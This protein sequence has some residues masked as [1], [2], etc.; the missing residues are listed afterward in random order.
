MK[1]RIFLLFILML[2]SIFTMPYSAEEPFVVL[3][4]LKGKAEVQRAGQQRWALIGK[5]GKLYNNDIIRV[6]DKSVIRLKWQNGSIIYVNSKLQLLINLHK[7][8]IN[9][10]FANYA[11]VFF[12]A[13]YFIVKKTLPRGVFTRQETKVYTPTAILAIRGTSFSVS[14]N[15]KSGF[16]RIG[17][18]NGTVLVKNI[19]KTQSL[20]LSAGYQT[21]VAMNAD[22]L[23]P[24]PLL[25]KEINLLKTWVPPEVI[26]EEMNTQIAQA[27]ADYATITG[28]LEEKIVVVPFGNSSIYKGKWKIGEKIATML[29]E[30]ISLKNR[31]ECDIV[32][33]PKAEADPIQIGLKEKARFVITGEI[34]HFE[35]IRRAEI[36]AAADKYQELSIAKI[37]LRIHLI[38]AEA[39][40]EIYKNDFCQDVSGKN[41]E[42]NSWKYI[43]TLKFDL[44]DRAFTS[45]IL[46]KAL[47]STLDQ[48]S[49]HLS[50]HMGFDFSNEPVKRK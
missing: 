45:S 7:D 9:N 6:L 17:I 16:T 24:E 39:K 5:D 14:V 41:I 29:A 25:K 15:K 23:L 26:I 36:T 34:E 32:S 27:K 2:F 10:I 4:S 48:S 49:A 22:P 42:G 38:D 11:T 46:G 31:V 19:L 47:T 50:R 13:V 21:K 33:S 28:K 20:F 30:N 40:K 1:S 18:I 12:G 35:I 44:K 8:T 3:D 43:G 37:C